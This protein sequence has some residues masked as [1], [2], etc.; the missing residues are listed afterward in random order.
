MKITGLDSLLKQIDKSPGRMTSEL[1][2]RARRM[3]TKL[4]GAARAGVPVDEGHL[5]NSIQGFAQRDGDDVTAGAR[6]NYDVA[7]YHEFGTG[8]VGEARNHPLAAE[9]GITHVSEGWVYQS[10]KVAAARGEEYIKDVKGGHVYTEGVPARA[11]MY[12]AGVALEDEI[13]EEFGAAVTEVF[14]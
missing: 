5:R 8:P 12:N 4:A 7:I 6:T 2:K 9:L 11:F 13:M 10:E 3:A 14:K 1:E